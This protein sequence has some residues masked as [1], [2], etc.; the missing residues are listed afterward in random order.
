MA[1]GAAGLAV[2][3]LSAQPAGPPAPAPM[4]TPGVRAEALAVGAGVER[5]LAPGETQAWSV[6]LAAGRPYRVAA[7][8]LGIDVALAVY[9][10]AGRR[11]AVA[12]GPLERWGVEAVLVRPA[13]AGRFRVEIASRLRGVGKG[14]YRIVCD[15]LKEATLAESEGVAALAAATAAGALLVEPPAHRE[16]YLE[17]ALEGFLQAR[18]HSA[19]A[20]DR[21][22]EAE[23]V[24]ILAA[25]S[26]RQGQRQQAAD[27]YREAAELWR[28]L[29][30]PGREIRAWNDLGLCLWELGDLAAADAALAAGQTLAAAQ[31]DVYDLADL[32]NNECLIVHARG[33]LRQAV[34]CYQEVVPRF[35]ELGESRDEASVLNNLGFAYSNLGELRPAEDDYGQAL[36]L[37]RAAGDQAGVAQTLNNLAVLYRKLGDLDRA[38]AHYA[39]ER[40]IAARL[41]D[42]QQE[43]A[44]LNNL[45]VAYKALGEVDRARAY[46]NQALTLR[47]A[48]QDR[49]GE[50]ATLNNLALLARPAGEP[51][52]LP[53]AA[54]A[55][56]A[57]AAAAAAAAGATSA[58]L[59]LQALALAR[60]TSDK[61]AEA[62]TLSYLG[63]ARAV[64]GDAAGALTALDQALVLERESGARYDEA[65]TLRAKAEVAAA[66]ATAGGVPLIPPAPPA[67]P[68][69]AAAP[70]PA[71]AAKPPARHWFSGWGKKAAAPKPKPEPGAEAMKPPPPPAQGGRG[72]PGSTLPSDD[73]VR[74][75]AGTPFGEA[76]ASFAQS[77]AFWRAVG[78][79]A[80]EAATLAARAR[81]WRDAGRLEEARAD[82]E[83]AVG[84]VEELR[85]R[86]GSADLRAA[87]L[88]SRRDTYD[89]FIDILMRL[90]AAHPGKGYD[91]AALEASERARARALLDLLRESGVD[92]RAGI[93][94][95]LAARRRDLERDLTFKVD[96]RMTLLSRLRATSP[97][98]S[99]TGASGAAA[100]AAGAVSAASAAP[101]AVADTPE[102]RALDHDIQ[103]VMADLD[104][105]DAEIRRQNPRYASLV[106]P[107]PL[108]VYD[109]QQ[110]L[111][112]D[113]VLLEYALGR[114]RSFLWA[115][116]A[117][118]LRAFVLPGREEI[119]AAARTLYG[120]LSTPP[121]AGQPARERLGEALGRTLLNPLADTLGHR[122]LAIVADG[123]LHYIPFEVLPEPG[124]PLATP[125]ALSS[126]MEAGEGTFSAGMGPGIASGRA[127]GSEVG[128]ATGASSLEEPRQ[129]KWLQPLLRRHEVV[130]LPSASVLAIERASRLARGDRPPAG[131]ADRLAIVLADPVFDRDDSRLAAAG[132]AGGTV[133]GS[134]ADGLAGMPVDS[135][136]P[137]TGRSARTAGGRRA[138]RAVARHAEAHLAANAEDLEGRR[139][140]RLRFSRQEAEAISGLAPAGAVTTELGFD[141]S[142]DLALSGRLRAYRYVHFAT[143][144]D[145][146]AARPE[147]SGLVLSRFDAAGHPQAGFLRLRDIYDLDL[148]ADLVVL[149]GCQTALG[150]DIRG[151]GLLGLTRGFLYA[152]AERVM[153]SLWEIDDH[154][155]ADLMALFY[156]GLWVD[157]LPPAAALRRA[158]LAL[159]GERRFRDPYY[160]GAF[161]LQGDWR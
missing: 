35:H 63:E 114:E 150:K 2:A 134:P 79:G 28:Q 25:L 123:A 42:R 101:A 60:A 3:A 158:R 93:D 84:A 9:D 59:H 64:A 32:R 109:I 66:L 67:V 81:A 14:R 102:I 145:F 144:G 131:E 21:A 5:P 26:R 23:A 133:D 97:A 77:L 83:A 112:A 44:T 30:R 40:E 116:D 140:G 89:L 155:T 29:A 138:G 151:E 148:G 130:E 90:D 45:G 121:V 61:S 92:M 117:T 149:S 11:V 96:R 122:R 157:H 141:A 37:R 99:A 4:S 62:L 46:F 22:G 74:A 49:R 113:T 127:T 106:R 15:E 10:A 73:G 159:A 129:T 7:E 76:L 153:A 115:V 143:H 111:D 86:L 24:T 27:L 39:E 78:D 98:A 38:L 120:A 142:R 126:S 94:P 160:W 128:P 52:V 56:L 13:A 8:Q 54:P 33:D 100:P 65:S 71:A 152:G 124:S 119:E 118:S 58:G 55:R 12:D 147:L 1:V 75:W 41:D 139:F 69:P 43:A 80:D 16:G 132:K 19:A 68:P 125:T 154:A 48:L 91:R 104:S 20:G 161:L 53:L 103:G 34:S 87:F 156:R 88:G 135:S 136:S 6:G 137:A 17:A 108:S 95:A 18:A 36:A 51:L 107:A 50:I 105:L 82:A 31:G 72:T 110:L 85:I 146:D 47:R 70:K 57:P